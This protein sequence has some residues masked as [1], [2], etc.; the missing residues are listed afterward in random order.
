MSTFFKGIMLSILFFLWLVPISNNIS[1]SSA[2]SMIY[3]YKDDSGTPNYTMELDTIPE[4]YR[5]RAVP[6]DSE[7]SSV[8][9]SVEPHQP[10]ANVRVVT[11]SGEYQMGDHD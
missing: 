8:V 3:T 11:A 7:T 1:V 4:K 9:T 10:A 5:S 6:I 2:A